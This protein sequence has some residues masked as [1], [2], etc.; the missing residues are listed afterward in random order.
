MNI[1]ALVKTGEYYDSITLMSIQKQLSQLQDIVEIGVMMGSDANKAIFRQAQLWLPEIEN[2]QAQDL[3]ICVKAVN[4]KVASEALAVAE[5]LLSEDKR[6][7]S[8]NVEYFPKSFETARKSLPQ[9]NILLVSVPGNYARDEAMK[10]LRSGLHVMIFSDNVP[11][12]HELQLKEFAEQQGLLVM[13]PDCGTAII[14]GTGLGFA[15]AVRRGNIGIIGASGTG[16]QEVSSLIHN[17]NQGIS[18]ALG[19]GGRDLSPKIG[20][21]TMLQSLELLEADE[22]TQVVVLISKPP[23]TTV[24]QKVLQRATQCPKPVVVNFLGADLATHPNLTNARTLAEAARFAVCLSR[25]ERPTP[26]DS[27]IARWQQQIGECKKQRSS[28][29]KYLRALYSGG[30]LAYESLLLLEPILENVYSNLSKRDEFLLQ[31]PLQSIQHSIIDLGEDEYTVGRPHPMIDNSFKAKRLVQEAM[32]QETAVLLLDIVLGYGSQLE[33]LADLLPAIREAQ[34]TAAEQK[35][36]LAIVA[37]VCGTDA[38]PQERQKI[39]QLLAE[40]DVLVTNNNVEAAQL[41]SA[42]LVD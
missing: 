4:A 15:N 8:L 23:A 36:Y 12:E 19:T 24:A 6:S 13:G 7:S 18:H 30:T 42:L 11:V 21:R 10:A 2:A 40:N 39:V 1:A 34:K 28:R 26:V 14:H 41:A 3:V 22:Q 16:I 29:Q 20:A 33:P 5:K 27:S 32:E 37:Y 9:A 38:D 35:R 25:G 17:Q 31:N